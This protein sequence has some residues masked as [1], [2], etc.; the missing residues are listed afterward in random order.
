LKL[1]LA[2]F[3]FYWREELMTANNGQRNRKGAVVDTGAGVLL[4]WWMFDAFCWFLLGLM[5]VTILWLLYDPWLTVGQFLVSSDSPIPG[6]GLISQI[7]LVGGMIASAMSNVVGWVASVAMTVVN[8]IQMLALLNQTGH[9]A[10]K[11]KWSKTLSW[12]AVLAWLGELWVALLAYPIYAG[13]W[14]GFVADLPVP[15]FSYFDLGAVTSVLFLM[16]LFEVSLYFAVI[17]I[18]A[19]KHNKSR[20]K[21]KARAK[22]TGQS[23]QPNQASSGRSGQ[24]GRVL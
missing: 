7:P 6:V 21:A 3:E 22:T 4:A 5:A 24:N 20:S 10:L 9:L 11:P 19:L 16:G 13:G 1:A 14:A 17:L 15:T 23:S 2:D 18:L 12:F 8:V